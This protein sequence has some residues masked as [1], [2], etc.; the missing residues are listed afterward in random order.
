MYDRAWA[1]FRQDGRMHALGA[2]A[3]GRLVGITHFFIHANTSGPDV[4]YLQDL[5]TARDLRGQGVGRALIAAV[6]DWAR[7][8]CCCR[9]SWMHHK[10][11]ESARRPYDTQER[12]GVGNG[13]VGGI[14]A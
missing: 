6:A 5:F 11:N 3:G 13:W 4:C 1:L 9:L 12:R 8:Q 10:N 2:K 7:A 14:N